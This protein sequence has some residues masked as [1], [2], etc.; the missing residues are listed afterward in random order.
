M[1]SVP[2]R[3]I[4]LTITS[5]ARRRRAPHHTCRL[6]AGL[7]VELQRISA[8]MQAQADPLVVSL[9]ASMPDWQSTTMGPAASTPRG[10]PSAG[11]S[12]TDEEPASLPPQSLDCSAAI[13][14]A[15][16]AAASNM[17]GVELGKAPSSWVEADQEFCSSA[18]A[19][20]SVA[21]SDAG[22]S[23]PLTAQ[24]SSSMAPLIKTRAVQNPRKK[25][26]RDGPKKARTPWIRE[27]GEKWRALSEEERAKQPRWPPIKTTKPALSASV[28][29]TVAAAPN[30][31]TATI[32][33]TVPT[34]V[35]T[36]IAAPSWPASLATGSASSTD[37]P[38]FAPAGVGVGAPA[39]VAGAAIGARAPIV[40]GAAAFS[41]PAPPL[42][43]LPAPPPA[44]A[45][46]LGLA[47]CA[48]ATTTAAPWASLPVVVG[49]AAFSTPAPPM[50]PPPAAARLLGLAPCA[51]A[52]TTAAPWASL[53]VAVAVPVPPPFPV[54]APGHPNPPAVDQIE[55]ACRL[56]VSRMTE[57]V[58]PLAGWPRLAG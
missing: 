35:P 31:A 48:A 19:Q 23:V 39:I 37:T 20:I 18:A 38:V 56:A 22:L 44:A 49:A 17:M 6:M 43:P 26:R 28:A 1:C 11:S 47:P 40:V 33:T 7:F 51:A 13:E 58:P 4:R 45:P 9:R 53:P 12:V 57:A 15:C 42:A 5:A 3:C 34:C 24:E 8:Q 27:L 41:T 16:Q 25:K 21:T 46:L 29:A 54:T 36:P 52:T 50:A 30:L 32:A 55:L 10:P 2:R 14:T